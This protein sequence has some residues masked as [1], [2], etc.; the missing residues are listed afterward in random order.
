M[1]FIPPQ[2]SVI[3]TASEDAV[4]VLE[5]FNESDNEVPGLFIKCGDTV[6]N[7][8]DTFSIGA[9]GKPNDKSLG[10]ENNFPDCVHEI[11]LMANESIVACCSIKNAIQYKI[12]EK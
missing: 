8:N 10:D 4:V 5:L 2:K 9:I 7:N 11:N 1:K 12:T 3:Y 6:Y